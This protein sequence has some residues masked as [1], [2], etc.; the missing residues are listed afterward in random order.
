MGLE[1]IA[2]PQL[3]LQRIDIGW[4]FLLLLVRFTGVF[5]TCPG[6]GM[7]VGGLTVRAPAI[8]VFAFA[9]VLGSPPAQIPTNTILATGMMFSEL[10][11]GAFLGLLP[12][13][14]IA[15]IQTAAS[16][17]ST[18]MGLQA[19]QLIDPTLQIS[20]PDIA[21]IFGDLAVIIFISLG[22]HYTIVYAAAGMGGVIVPGSF[23]A[24][25]KIVELLINHSAAVFEMG[26]LFSAPVV[27]A[28]LITNVV[29]ALISR[30]VPTVN[31]FMVSFPLTIAIGLVLSVF[32]VSEMAT[33][34]TPW[35][36]R[37]D[38]TIRTVVEY[39]TQQG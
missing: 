7:G 30:A 31:V 37:I 11:F 16:I 32:L 5:M 6:L 25:D 22:G 38:S 17:C 18:S 4:T 3:L 14:A 15:G 13:L 26:V 12:Q 33:F 28:L 20:L 35:L 19:S 9:A 39:G 34:L 24:S 2:L 29:L 10:I 27:V 1:F 36:N 23:I 8:M 21:R